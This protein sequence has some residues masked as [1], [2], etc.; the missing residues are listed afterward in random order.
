MKCAECSYAELSKH[1]NGPSRYYC[2]HTQIKTE[3]NAGREM[4]CRCE[5]NSEELTI[6]TAP[7]WSPLKRGSI[8][9]R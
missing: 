1:N 3:T 9:A 7:R 6:K 4:I 8:L 2:I 5:R